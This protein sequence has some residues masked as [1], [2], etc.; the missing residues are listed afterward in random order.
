MTFPVRF[1]IANDDG[2]FDES[3]YTPMLRSRETGG[4]SGSTGLPTEK[5]LLE[6][7]L[8]DLT[9]AIMSKYDHNDRVWNCKIYFECRFLR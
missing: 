5:E 8:W 2:F 9:N 6:A 4:M 7:P 3:L 1:Y